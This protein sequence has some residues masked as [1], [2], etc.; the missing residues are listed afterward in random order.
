MAKTRSYQSKGENLGDAVANAVRD[1]IKEG[2]LADFLRKHSSEVVN[3][4]TTEFDMETAL[5][6]RYEEGI[7]EG[8]EEGREE[9]KEEGMLISSLIIKHHLNGKDEN[10]ISD[11]LNTPKDK[12]RFIINSF[13]KSL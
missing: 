8:R 4:L 6:V 11:I 5:A 7:E 12:V 2:V 9:G 3:M 1:C 13:N 10:A